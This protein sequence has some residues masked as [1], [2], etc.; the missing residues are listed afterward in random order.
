MQLYS[1]SF[2]NADNF[3][4]I[5]TYP[6]Q[7]C[8][9]T[10]LLWTNIGCDRKK[11]HSSTRNRPC[12]FLILHKWWCKYISCYSRILDL[13]WIPKRSNSYKWSA[14]RA[15][16]YPLCQRFWTTQ[17]TLREVRFSEGRF[18]PYLLVTE[19]ITYRTNYDTGRKSHWLQAFPALYSAPKWESVLIRLLLWAFHLFWSDRL[20]HH[21]CPHVCH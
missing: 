21:F 7:R 1:L 11:Q 15:Q 8:L 2:L 16:N 13:Q 12:S 19:T 20:L 4:Y 10:W 9:F 14:S 18:R 6:F 5:R 17:T 3:R